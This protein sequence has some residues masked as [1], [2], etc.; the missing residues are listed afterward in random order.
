MMLIIFPYI[1]KG[2]FLKIGHLTSV[3]S[4]TGLLWYQFTYITKRLWNC[5]SGVRFGPQWNTGIS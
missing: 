1:K 2:G 4:M 3:G 5:R